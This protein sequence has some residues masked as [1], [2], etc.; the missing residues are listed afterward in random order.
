[1]IKRKTKKWFAHAVFH[2]NAELNI[3]CFVFAGG[4]PS[5][6]SPWRKLCPES[7]NLIPVLYPGRET[8][9]GEKMPDTLEELLMQFIKDNP[10]L[11]EKPYAIWGHC[12]GSLLGLELAY[13]Q[14]LSGNPPEVFIVTGSESPK[15]ALRLIPDIKESFDEVSDDDILLS[16]K[17]YNLMP[18]DMLNNPDF[19]KYFLPI[20][21]A[22]LSMFSKYHYDDSKKLDCPALIMNG[23][24]D[25]LLIPK[26]VD[27]WQECF[28]QEIKMLN[29][30]GGHYF[31]NDHKEEVIQEILNFLKR[32]GESK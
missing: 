22:D 2:E 26:N 18:E 30:S 28:S 14:I 7:C 10:D 29:F 6:F 24:D 16:L 4:S 11:F 12:S 15:Y 32:K 20:Y 31:V 17:S 19:R 1:M 5:F 9:N 3:L 8:R 27:K 25:K 21:R 13:T 23:D